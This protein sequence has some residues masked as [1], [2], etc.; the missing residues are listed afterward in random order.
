MKG[1]QTGRLKKMAGRIGGALLALLLAVVF[2]VAVVMAEPRE[3]DRLRVQQDQPLLAA[4]PA[5]T[6]TGEHELQTLLDSFPAQVLCAP[7]GS[8]LALTGGASYDVAYEGGFARMVEMV[9]DLGNGQE[10]KVISIYPARALELLGKGDYRLSAT[11]GAS[12]AGI[13]S[14]RMENATQVRMHMQGENAL[15]AVVLP[16]GDASV[17]TACLRPLQLLGGDQSR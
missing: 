15:Y 17:L 14:V 6:I 4:S 16:K 1:K 2:Y 10:M 3:Q 12:I 8:G 7:Q 13:L 11:G 5:V 9:Y